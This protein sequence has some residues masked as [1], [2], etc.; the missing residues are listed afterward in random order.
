MISRK[1]YSSIEKSLSGTAEG[2]SRVSV[3]LGVAVQP[4][5]PERTEARHC[6]ERCT[7]AE[8]SRDDHCETHRVGKPSYI[9]TT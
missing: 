1:F 4:V 5:G 2:F 3:M 8:I 9:S 6:E 7:D